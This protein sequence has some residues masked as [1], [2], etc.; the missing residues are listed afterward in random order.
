MTEIG[1]LVDGKY[2]ILQEIGRG[3]MSIVYMAMDTRLNKQWA[4]KEI[5]KK[6]NGKEDEIVINS[7]MAE[8]DLM[9][10]LDH[11]VLPRI[12]DIID[13]GITMYV[14]M[15]FIEGRSLEAVL[16]EKGPQPEEK[17]IKWAMQLCEG[18]QYL[19]SQN[20]PVIYRD[21]KPDNVMLKDEEK[22][23]IKLIDFGI[24]REYKEQNTKDTTVLGTK[25]YA[26]PEQ[27]SGQTDPRS[28]IYALGMTMHR[29][30]TGVDP[31]ANAY[32]PVRQWNPDLSEAIETIINKCVEP[33]A[34]NRYQNCA[35]LLYDLEHPEWILRGYKKK[36]KMRLA[37]FIA[38]ASLS[39]LAAITGV[40]LNIAATNVNNQDYDLNLASSDPEKYFTAVGIYPERA[41]AYNSLIEYYKNYEGS[42][43]EITK[44][45]NIIESHT[46]SLDANTADI[47]DMYYDMGKLYFS[48]YE[49]S[50]KSRAIGAQNFFKIAAES[51]ASYDKKEIAICYYSICKFMTNQSTTAEHA[52]ADYEALIEEIQTA[53]ETVGNAVDNEANYDKIS[54]YYV[55]MLLLNDQSEYMAGVGF[56]R[57][58]L[59]DLMESLHQGANGITSTLTYVNSLKQEINNNYN[60]LID[61]INA[62]Y[63]EVEKRQ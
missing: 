32:T 22:D 59:L 53:M 33:A 19:H 17:V 20:P 41:D 54:L 30:L 45:G 56:E 1:T 58:E 24:A 9:K 44:V 29:L 51:E 10:R 21:M 42:N 6:G 7:L 43:E 8:A 46:D 47:A 63:N 39:V 36:Q 14:I 52:L 15:D 16:K 37:A 35:E 34:E 61:N 26:P 3:G 50:F 55:T 28:D 11:P 25:G 27:Y 49:G 2:K 57:Q 18:L 62:K 12:V 4:I 23:I 48:Q 40:A 38:S 13:N 5:K 31:I 60:L